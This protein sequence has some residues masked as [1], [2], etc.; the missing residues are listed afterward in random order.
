VMSSWRVRHF[1]SSSMS[2][3]LTQ[4]GRASSELLGGAVRRPILPELAGTFQLS[5]SYPRLLERP[6]RSCF[7]SASS[8]SCKRRFEVTTCSLG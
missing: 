2:G 6:V 4:L 3:P 1:G 8:S 7:T 5:T